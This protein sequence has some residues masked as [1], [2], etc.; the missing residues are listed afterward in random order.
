MAIAVANRQVI[1]SES[2]FKLVFAQIT[3]DT[4]YPTGGSP[5]VANALGFQNVLGVM[6]NNKGG[7]DVEYVRAADKLKISQNAAINSPHSEVANTTNL[8]AITVDVLAIGT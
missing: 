6:V 7:Y 3:L 5:G 1:E 4:S 2:G 8:S